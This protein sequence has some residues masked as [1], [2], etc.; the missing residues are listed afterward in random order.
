MWSVG[1]VTPR[2]EAYLA[3]SGV[4]PSSDSALR[5]AS[6]D[7]ARARII[8]WTVTI[9]VVSAPRVYRLT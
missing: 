8:V 5:D 9:V 7:S 3:G 2:R 4:K 1:S 6:S